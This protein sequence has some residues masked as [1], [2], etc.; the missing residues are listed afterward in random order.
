MLRLLRGIALAGRRARIDLSVCGEMAG[1][2]VMVALL[3]G[4]GIPGVQHGAGRDSGRERVLSALDTREAVVLARRARQAMS[5][6]AARALVEPLVAAVH[7][8]VTRD[9]SGS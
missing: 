6:D 3:V 9:P 4:L 1:D 5:S 2:P 7:S 8:A